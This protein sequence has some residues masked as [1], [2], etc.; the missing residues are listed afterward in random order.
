MTIH[1]NVSLQQLNTFGIDAAARYFADIGSEDDLQAVLSDPAF[2]GLQKMPLGGG[3][4]ILF[5]GNIDGLV[6]HNRMEGME[7]L[8]DDGREALLR[9]AGG[10]TWHQ[11]V[12]FAIENGLGGIE[13]LSLIPGSA[14]AAPIQNIGAYGAEL[15]DVFAGLEAVALDGEERRTFTKEE[16]AFGYRMSVFKSQYKNKYFI[17][18]VTLRLSRNTVPNTSYGAIEQELEKTGVTTPTIRNVSDA[19]IRIRSSKLPDPREIGNAGS[20]FKNPEVPLAQYESLKAAFPGMVAY[21]SANGMKLAAGWLIEQC[22]WK[23]KVAGRVGMHARQ[24]LVLVNYGG[25]T[26]EELYRHALKVQQSVR[27]RFGV[28]LE[29]E[30]NI[31]GS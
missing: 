28:A 11:V 16:C 20:F 4:N 23:G 10:T 5:R 8:E 26:G 14:G 19:V 13:N 29:M 22:G 31:V 21:P 17:T 18:S 12:L 7:I 24:A 27:D 25:A 30:V 15:K 3:S 6:L 1:E 2:A 9:A